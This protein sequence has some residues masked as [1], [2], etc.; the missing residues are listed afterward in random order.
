LNNL[1]TRARI[2]SLIILV[3]LP[4]LGLTVLNT[5]RERAA[6]YSRAGDEISR[7]AQVAALHQDRLVESSRQTLTALSQILPE[8]MTD[9]ERCTRYFANIQKSTGDRYLSMGIQSADG[10]PYCNALG[11]LSKTNAGEQQYFRL[12]MQSGK[13]AIGDFQIGPVT[14]KPSIYFASPVTDRDDRIKGV[15]YLALDLNALSMEFAQLAVPQ[16]ALLTV[17][18]RNGIVLARLPQRHARIGEKLIVPTVLHNVLA[19]ERGVFEATGTDGKDRLFAFQEVVKNPDGSLPLTV[20]ISIPRNIIYAD[21]NAALTRSIMEILLVTLL[22]IAGAWYGSERLVLRDIHILLQVARRISRGELSARTGMRRSRDELHQLGHAFDEMAREIED[23]NAR[24]G[25][26]MK[27]LHQ[28]ASTDTLTGLYNRRHLKEI[29]PRE[30]LRARRNGSTLALIMADID[31]FKKINDT[32]GHA[33]GDLVLKALA[34]LLKDSI[35]GGDIVF[36]HGGEE[37]VVVLPETTREGA[38]LKAESLRKAVSTLDVEFEGR[39]LGKITSSFGVAL[40]PD[41]AHEPELLLRAA[42]EALYAAKG[43]G[44]DRVMLYELPGQPDTQ[45]T[46]AAPTNSDRNDER[47][48]ST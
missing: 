31:H 7:L 19:N 15:A 39:A 36:R 30:L 42:D 21:A 37:F 34:A 11:R 24:L 14:G 6:A 18:D 13:F 23:R 44:R 41:H 12:A 22:L 48:T 35:R 47:S 32:Y 45:D 27:E 46:Y 26:A 5:M 1:S 40:F 8:L 25:L 17:L 2:V 3:A 20:L 28:Q 10:T 16:Y 38:R 9:R 29:L 4:I 33:A 43:A